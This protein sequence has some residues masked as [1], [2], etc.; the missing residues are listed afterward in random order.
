LTVEAYLEHHLPEM[1]AVTEADAR[2][3]YDSHRQQW[4]QQGRREV[5]NIFLRATEGSTADRLGE[6]ADEIRRRFERGESFAALAE[7]YSDSESRHQGGFIG[8]LE[9]HRLPP[10]AAEVVFTLEEGRLSEPL[11]TPQGLHL[12]LVNGIVEHRDVS[13]SE[14]QPQIVAR[15]TADR[16]DALVSELAAGIP[17]VPDTFVARGEDLVDLMRHGEAD[18]V[19]LRVGTFRLNA[20]Q[21]RQMTAKT[22][23]NGQ[24]PSEG[25]PE[26]LVE[27]MARRERIFAEASRQGLTGESEVVFRLET[28]MT[29]AEL[30]I[31]RQRVIERSLDAD[32]EP[33]T[34]WFETNRRR[35]STPLRLE[36]SRLI[37]P[38]D[39][40]TIDA[41]VPVLEGLSRTDGSS[42]ALEEVAES[43]GGRIERD[44]WKT[45]NEIA[46]IR[47]M[48][49]RLASAL[50]VG[51]VSPPYRTSSTLEVLAVDG[52]QEPEA[53]ALAAVYDRVR[54]EY[55]KLYGAE[56]Y[57]RWARTSLAE[58]ELSIFTERVV[59]SG[60]TPQKPDAFGVG[61]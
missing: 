51:G 59:V 16:R 38:L 27:L 56:V 60:G 7:Q 45:L 47:P 15:L 31:R 25:L 11:E 26:R 8:W 43:L 35:F 58:A 42:D 29:R 14:A 36:I 24:A 18:A 39:V 22:I 12:F 52:R 34:A 28:A 53:Q 2:D 46:A 20:G 50:P 21:L 40:S 57:G 44:G 23:A 17:E 37:V 41:T 13:F 5:H 3:W 19:V 48:A 54:S 9:R 6:Q 49:A 55:L 1:E 10:E 61:G 30:N 33:M 32:P 4:V